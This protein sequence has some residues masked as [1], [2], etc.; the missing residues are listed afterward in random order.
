MAEFFQNLRR[1]GRVLW[2]APAFTVTT[3]LILALAIGANTAMFSILNAWLFRPLH[4]P[5][6]NQLVIVLRRDLSRPNSLPYFLFIVTRPIGRGG[7]ARSR[8]LAECS[9]APSR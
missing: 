9:G 2:H 7:F 6:A 1:A 4:F 5:N 8:V 3:V